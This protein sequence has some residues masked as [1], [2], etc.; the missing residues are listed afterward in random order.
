PAALIIDRGSP[1]PAA[2]DKSDNSDQSPHAPPSY[3]LVRDPAP[4]RAVTAALDNT[5]RV[6]LDSETTGLDPRADRVRLLSLS[7]DTIDGGPRTYLVDCFAV[8]PSPLWH[9]LAE[10]ELVLHNAVFDLGF[11]ARLGF[12]PAGKVHDTLLLSRLLT[13]GA[14]QPNDLAACA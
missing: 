13:A 9:A 14:Y 7:C 10:K 3:L 2:R 6:G 11:L 5:H 12:A 8:A 4:L 1:R